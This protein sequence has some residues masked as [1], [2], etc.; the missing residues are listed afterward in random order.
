MIR[1]AVLYG[2][3]SGEHEVSCASAAGILE[4]LDAG[5]FDV[6]PVRVTRDGVWVVGAD[7]PGPVGVAASIAAAIQVLEQVDVVL[8]AFH[9]RYGEDGTVQA[10]LEL[11]GVPY[12]GSGVSSSAVGMDKAWTKTLLAA[13]GL[14]V[15]DAVVLDAPAATVSAGE[16]ARLGLPVFVKPAREGSSIGVTRVDDWSQLDAAVAA[17]RECD[18]KVLVEAGIR[19]REVDVAVLEQPD[20]AL[21]CGPPLEILTGPAS[22][23]FDFEAK[24]QASAGTLMNVPADLDRHIIAVLHEQAELAFRTLGCSGLLRVDFFLRSIDGGVEP[25]INEVNTFPGFTEMSQYPRIWQ[26]AGL[27]YPTLLS[28][29]VDTA[30]A[31]K[32]S[33]AWP[34]IGQSA[35]G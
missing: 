19:G 3:P 14:T 10:L 17:A 8:P 7:D 27:D 20:G 26:A 13:A 18:T 31:G 35:R 25:V 32:R 6:T 33:A 23:F 12:I 22:G 1:I 2:G 21:V 16:R 4:H 9:G 30:L 34:A 11:V 24:Y 5:R 28:V 29:L 15:A